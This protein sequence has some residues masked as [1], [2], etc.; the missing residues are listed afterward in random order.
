MRACSQAASNVKFEAAPFFAVFDSLHGNATHIVHAGQSAGLLFASGEGDFELAAEALRIRVTQQELRAGL[1]VRCDVE[2]F[3]VAHARERARRNVTNGVAAG[4]AR[5]DADSREPSH[6][7]W[8]ISDMDIVEL[9]I[10]ASSDVKHT[11]G[12]FF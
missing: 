4:F 9:E 1:R 7:V 8:G 5:G 2:D 10:L 3:A 12:I 11:V 6:Q